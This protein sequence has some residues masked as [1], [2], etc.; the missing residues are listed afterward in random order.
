MRPAT[1]TALSTF[2]ESMP[3]DMTDI[4]AAFMAFPATSPTAMP[5]RRRSF[6]SQK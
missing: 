2:E 6:P 5:K 3:L 1:E 4:I